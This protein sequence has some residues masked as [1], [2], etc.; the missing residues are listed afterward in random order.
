MDLNRASLIGRMATDPEVRMAGDKAVCNFRLVTNSKK[1]GENKAEYHNVV[2][3]GKNAENVGTF[4]TRGSKVYL[5]G[6]LQTREWTANDGQKKQTT[7][8]VVDQIIF[9]DKP[10]A[11][12]SITRT[13]TI[14]EKSVTMSTLDFV[15]QSMDKS[16]NVMDIPPESIPF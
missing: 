13:T 7:E 8:I 4:L 10:D 2:C 12:Y 5:D 16:D 15:N 11:F 14:P 6:R 3:W 1:N 9:L